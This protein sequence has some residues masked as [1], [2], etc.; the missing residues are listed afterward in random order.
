LLV[1]SQNTLSE[2]DPSGTWAK[3]ADNLNGDST[4]SA[5]ASSADGSRYFLAGGASPTLTAT[6]YQGKTLWQIPLTDV[7]GHAQ[8]IAKDKALLLLTTD[9]NLMTLQA[10]TGTVCSQLHI[11]GDRRSTLWDDFGADGILRVG[12]AD[13]ILGLDWKTFASNCA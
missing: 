13:Q 2:V 10:A 12:L 3:V 11:Y 5:W 1:Y 7:S 8:I 4:S 9:G 6:D